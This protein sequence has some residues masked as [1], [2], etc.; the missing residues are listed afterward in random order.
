MGFWGTAL[1]LVGLLACGE[2]ALAQEKM[3]MPGNWVPTGAEIIGNNKNPDLTQEQKILKNIT[4]WESKRMLEDQRFN[5]EKAAKKIM[6]QNEELKQ[7][8][9][10]NADYTRQLQQQASPSA[11]I[12]CTLI[13]RDENGNLVEISNEGTAWLGRIQKEMWDAGK[14]VTFK[15]IKYKNSMQY[16]V[17]DEHENV[18]AELDGNGVRYDFRKRPTTIKDIMRQNREQGEV[19]KPIAGSGDIPT[20]YSSLPRAKDMISTNDLITGW[21][22]IAGS[23]K[24]VATAENK[25]L[26]RYLIDKK[27]ALDAKIDDGDVLIRPSI[28]G[29]PE[30]YQ[31]AAYGYY[32]IQSKTAGK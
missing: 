28:K 12:T 22:S 25:A 14:P 18:Y 17:A 31:N 27:F 1:G 10:Q 20:A 9:E 5:E 4:A 15:Y 2:P 23:E 6:E 32:A 30:I 8:L 3:P 16:L 26:G 7:Q 24:Q 13:S 19:K 29:Q 21:F 11:G